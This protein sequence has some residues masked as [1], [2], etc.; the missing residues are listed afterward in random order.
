MN[1]VIINQ[2][3]LNFNVKIPSN[4]IFTLLVS[5]SYC[6]LTSWLNVLLLFQR[7]TNYGICK[8]CF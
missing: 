7:L 4:D 1:A 8:V 6:L 3:K 2:I 5:Y